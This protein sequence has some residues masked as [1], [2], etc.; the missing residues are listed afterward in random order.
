MSAQVA[1][2]IAIGGAITGGLYALIALGLNLQYGLM[3]ILNVAHGEFLMLGAYLTYTLHVSLGINPLLTI[4]VTG[5]AALGAGLLLHRTLYARVLGER[6]AAQALESRSLL[7]SFGLLFVAQNAALLIWSA[8]LRGYSYLSTPLRLLGA[9][10]AANRVVA[11]ALA[12]AVGV[13]FYVFLRRSLVGK[14]VRALMQDPD[15]ARLV[16]IDVRRV[17][18]FCFGAGVAMSAVAG[19]LISMAFELTPFMG[20]ELHGHRAR[21]HHPRGTRQRAGQP[22]RRDR[23]GRGGDGGRVPGRVRHPAHRLLRRALAD[24]PPEAVGPAWSVGARSP[25]WCWPSWRRR[26][27]LSSYARSLTVAVL[28]DVCLASAWA[29][30]SGPTGYLS[31]ATGAFFGVGAYTAAL[32]V[33]RLAWP[34]PVVAGAAVGAGLALVVGALALRLRGPYFAIFTFGLAELAKHVLIWY[35]TRVT[36]T[37]GRLLLAPPG[38]WTLYY[39][40][41]GLTL[42]VVA[43]AA[44]LRRTQWGD[45]LIAIGADEERAE[46]L[47]IDTTRVK[48][49]TFAL[50]AAFM[51]ASGAAMAPRWTYLDPQVF[52]PLV[53]F[54]TVIMA[55][56][57]GA[58]S[59]GRPGAGRRVHRAG[60]G[61]LAAAV[62]LRLHAGARAHPDRRRALRPRGARRRAPP[63]R[64]RSPAASRV[65]DDGA[66]L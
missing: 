27:F 34:L 13:G 57:G 44:M 14:A 18:A 9:P 10:F 40:V 37:V 48:V 62:P 21:R 11:A 31:L 4:L 33:G 64:P 41:L 7:L 56:V 15:G 8:D 5:P 47:G 65:R 50:S 22:G 28:A 55:L 12:L 51:A 60:L 43:V 66:Q 53:S 2:D 36:G 25:F 19:S 30:F 17:H 29:F 49:L 54:Q 61:D 58:T 23:P 32:T 26:L 38:P 20:L 46:T 45:A 35:E 63:P 59:V 6:D 3:R 42:L 24:P 16:G 1:L 39:T 52:S